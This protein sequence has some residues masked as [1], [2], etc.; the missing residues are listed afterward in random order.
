LEKADVAPEIHEL[1]NKKVFEKNCSKQGSQ[2]VCIIAVL[3]HIYD[4]TAAERN[5]QIETLQEIAKKHRQHPFTWFW[6]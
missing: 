5:A 3:P 2:R 4:Q 1:T 6:T